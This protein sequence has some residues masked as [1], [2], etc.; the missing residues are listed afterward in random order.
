MTSAL[1]NQYYVQDDYGQAAGQVGTPGG[2]ASGEQLSPIFTAASIA[3][4]MTA[5]YLFCTTLQRPGRLVAMGGAPPWTLIT[6]GPANI[7]LTAVPSG[8]SY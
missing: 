7:A 2:G 1:A 3:N 6:P 4:A 8:L 5:A